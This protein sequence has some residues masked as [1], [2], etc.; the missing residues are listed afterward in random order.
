MT[1]NHG[2]DPSVFGV[3]HRK[4]S[5]LVISKKACVQLP[6]LRSNKTHWFYLSR[7]RCQSKLCERLEQSAD[8]WR[9]QKLVTRTVVF[10]RIHKCKFSACEGFPDGSNLS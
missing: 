1:E 9:V 5:A 3:D 4:K 6:V 2:D 10:V 7:Q 8:T